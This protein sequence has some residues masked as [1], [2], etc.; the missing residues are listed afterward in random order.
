MREADVVGLTDSYEAEW[1][2]QSYFMLL[3]PRA[4][5]SV[6]F[7][8]FML[9]VRMLDTKDEVIGRYELRF[10]SV[11]RAAGLRCA[12][13]H[14]AEGR[15]NPTIRRWRDLL[16][17]GFPFLKVALIQGRD[18][19]ADTQ[20]LET[21]LADSF[22]PRVVAALRQVPALAAALPGAPLLDDQTRE[23]AERLRPRRRLT[24]DFIGRWTGSDATA[25]AGRRL[26]EAWWRTDARVNLR[27]ISR[28]VA[29]Q[30]AI[31]FDGP[32]D[33]AVIQLQ[34]GAAPP[35]DASLQT[36]IVRAGLRIGVVCDGATPRWASATVSGHRQGRRP[37]APRTVPS[38][39]ALP[40]L[41]D[42]EPVQPDE[43][44]QAMG[45]TLLHL[46]QRRGTG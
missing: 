14:P 8:R 29:G 44:A 36:A 19:S 30:E 35:L 43:L 5:A 7:Q 26:I 11:L 40:G 23:L 31:D 9:D 25:D 24:I 15:G 3:K 38:I 2:V 21:I 41:G 28:D 10:A 22:E 32:A 16:A 33:V 45:D 20:G 18:A 39:H 27:P 4:L 42:G 17:A 46:V 13:L 34:D 1:H 12:V 6:A 37:S